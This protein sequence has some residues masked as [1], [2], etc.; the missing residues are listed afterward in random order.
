MSAGTISGRLTMRAQVERDR[1]AGS[2]GWGQR[3]APD[4]QPVGEPLPCFVWSVS[5]RADVTAERSASV[6][7][8]RG[9]FPAGADLQDRDELASVTDRAG[10]VL[11]H[12]RL[13][14][15]GR[16]QFKHTH[17]EADLRGIG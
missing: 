14:V 13:R 3:P 8:L 9:L 11:H 10:T 15:E 17:L 12:G 16:P 4:F 5:S 1:A 2:D 7:Q 6:E